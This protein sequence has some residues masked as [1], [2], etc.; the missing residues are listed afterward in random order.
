[1][2]QAVTETGNEGSGV[3]LLVMHAISQ[4]NIARQDQ[5]WCH[6]IGPQI[7]RQLWRSLGTRSQDGGGMV[8]QGAWDGRGSADREAR[9]VGGWPRR[10]LDKGGRRTRL[11]GGI[12]MGD[13]GDFELPR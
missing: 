2:K 3:G 11:A 5:G 9:G 7:D 1:M 13:E 4:C 8:E 6:R 12:I 10:A